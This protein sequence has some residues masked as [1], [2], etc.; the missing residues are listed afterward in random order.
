MEFFSMK[1]KERS[2][3]TTKRRVRLYTKEWPP[4]LYCTFIK[5]IEHKKTVEGYT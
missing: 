5:K 4:D 1:V 2:L 3:N